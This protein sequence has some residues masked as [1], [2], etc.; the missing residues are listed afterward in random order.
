MHAFYCKLLCMACAFCLCFVF[1]LQMTEQTTVWAQLV[2]K[3][4]LI[5]SCPDGA[6]VANL[7][8]KIYDRFH[9][10][11]VSYGKVTFLES[12]IQVDSNLS[13]YQTG[14]TS[15]IVVFPP[16]PPPPGVGLGLGLRLGLGPPHQISLS[17][18]SLGGM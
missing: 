6:M 16:P 4:I 18:P 3:G 13:N 2:T 9:L 11:Y 15:P 7:L 14:Y 1:S 5:Y 12:E 8:E 17:P 10:P